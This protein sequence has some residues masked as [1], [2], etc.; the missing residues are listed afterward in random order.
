M[1]W[2]KME[3]TGYAGASDFYHLGASANNL[4]ALNDI[5]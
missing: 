1:L 2:L 5:Y 3:N 4:D